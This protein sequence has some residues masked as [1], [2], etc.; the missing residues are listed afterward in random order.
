MVDDH[1]FIKQVWTIAITSMNNLVRCSMLFLALLTLSE[2]LIPIISY[3]C[4]SPTVK[5]ATICSEPGDVLVLPLE[6]TN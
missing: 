1:F 3:S 4:W 6:G 2:E 5:R